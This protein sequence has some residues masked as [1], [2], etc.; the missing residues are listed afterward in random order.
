MELHL[1]FAARRDG[2]RILRMKE[3]IDGDRLN[4]MIIDAFVEGRS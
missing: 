3:I 1:Q 4:V 2:D